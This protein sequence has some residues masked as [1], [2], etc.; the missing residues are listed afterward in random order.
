VVFD[1]NTI[2]DKATFESPHAYSEGFK[3][4]MVNGKIV[5]QDGKTTNERPGVILYGK[6]KID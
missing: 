4:V 6:A 1:E 5:L 3:M 2:E